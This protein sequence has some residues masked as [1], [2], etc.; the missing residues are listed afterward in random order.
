MGP[1]AKHPSGTDGRAQ[2]NYQANYLT[3]DPLAR[4]A[5]R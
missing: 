3:S 2:A 4:R 5:G 1:A